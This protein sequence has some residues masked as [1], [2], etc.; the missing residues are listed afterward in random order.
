MAKGLAAVLLTIAVVGSPLSALFCNDTGPA[1]MAC[2][3]GQMSE[4]NRPGSTEDCCKK[5]PI[6]KEAS[7]A[8]TQ[9]AAAK[10][11]WTFA[12]S[13][14]AGLPVTVA[15]VALPRSTDLRPGSR[16]AWADLAPPPPSILRV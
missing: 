7:S 5:V 8:P 15:A 11:H 13:L 12:V 14:E 2:C 1:A 3:Q 16:T 4:C 10:Q 6:E 9:P